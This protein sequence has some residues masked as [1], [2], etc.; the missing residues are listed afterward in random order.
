[1]FGFRTPTRAVDGSTS[2]M[3]ERMPQEIVGVASF[4]SFASTTSEEQSLASLKHN[5][6]PKEDEGKGWFD[7]WEFADIADDDDDNDDGGCKTPKLAA[8][9]RELWIKFV[10]S[11]SPPTTSAVAGSL[12]GLLQAS[13]DDE[14]DMEVKALNS[15]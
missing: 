2:A 11:L 3:S 5:Q 9:E 4:A 6:S 15:P 8:K 12:L 13:L 14:S 1:M 10:S 7:D